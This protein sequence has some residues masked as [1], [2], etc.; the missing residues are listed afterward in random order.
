MFPKK[1][2]RLNSETRFRS[3]G[4]PLACSFNGQTVNVF[5]NIFLTSTVGSICSDQFLTVQNYLH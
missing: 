3:P 4:L 2:E 1:E 5:G